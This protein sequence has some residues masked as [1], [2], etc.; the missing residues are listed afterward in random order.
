MT[1]NNKIIINFEQLVRGLQTTR[2][3]TDKKP[4]ANI[5]FMK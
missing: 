2:L 5:R 3:Q 4:A 1:M